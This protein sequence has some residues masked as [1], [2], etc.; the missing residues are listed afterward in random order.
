MVPEAAQQ[1]KFIHNKI[2]C[3]AVF[4]SQNFD[5]LFSTQKKGSSSKKFNIYLCAYYEFKFNIGDA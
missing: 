3:I 4:A 2:I 5:N 1:Q